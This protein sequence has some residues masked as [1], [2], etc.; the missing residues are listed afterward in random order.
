MKSPERW[1]RCRRQEPHSNIGEGLKPAKSRILL[2]RKTVVVAKR[3]PCTIPLTI[4]TGETRQP[5]TLGVNPG[6]KQVGL[7]ASTEKAELYASE[8]E[9]RQDLPDLSAN[10]S[11]LRQARLNRKTRYRAPRF[12]NR[13][14]SKNKG[15]LAPSVE[16]RIRVHLSRIVAVCRILPVAKIV[17]ETASFDTQR[18]KN[19]DIAGEE[20]RQGKELGFWNVREYVLFRDDHVCQHCRGKS[21]DPILNVHH[22]ENRRTGGDA[23]NNRITLCETCHKAHHRGEIELKVKRGQ[24]FKAETFMG[25]MRR[26]I[27]DRLKA[28][29]PV[30][31]VHH[32]YE[33]EALPF[34]TITSNLRQKICR[35]CAIGGIFAAVLGQSELLRWSSRKTIV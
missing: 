9:R 2:K 25:I 26:T 8:V 16:N 15:W 5:I 19:P 23:P 27:L 24:S 11:A 17:V 28:A 20:Y 34:L 33:G 13:V 22:L 29:H 14:R 4:A 3:T 35:N 32:T 1:E 12:D 21:K 10:R 31:E 6:Y 18:L 7:S 30:R